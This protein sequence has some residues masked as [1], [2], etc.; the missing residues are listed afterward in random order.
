MIK[1]TLDESLANSSPGTAELTVISKCQTLSDLQTDGN[2]TQDV[3]PL[4]LISSNNSCAS[5]TTS[6]LKNSAKSG[7]TYNKENTAPP[8]KRYK[9]PKKNVTSKIKTMIESSM[10][11]TI[12]EPERKHPTRK[13]NGKWDDVMSKIEAGKKALGRP[14]KKEVKSRVLQGIGT[15]SGSSAGSSSSTRRKIGD[16][17]NNA[18]GKDKRWEQKHKKFC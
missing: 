11:S 17:N 16:A 7:C 15:S 10:T 1:D 13:K 5:S 9:M 2:C 4:K 18:S 3:I 8:L 14:V 6:S 12:R